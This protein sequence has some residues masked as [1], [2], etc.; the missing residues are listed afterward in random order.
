MIQSLDRS[1]DEPLHK[2]LADVLRFAI[3]NGEFPPGEQIPSE[4]RLQS[5]F[6]VSRSVVRQALASLTSL[7]LIKRVKGSGAT[8]VSRVT[9]HRLVQSQIGLAAQV[10]SLGAETATIVQSM[11]RLGNP[12]GEF[13]K[14]DTGILFIERI[15]SVDEVPIA[16]V[17][18]WLPLPQFEGLT[19]T[20][21]EN[22]SLHKIMNVRYGISL[23]GGTR[24]VRA[25]SSDNSLSK[26]LN[27]QKGSPLLL[28]TGENTDAQGLLVERFSTWHRSDLVS[29]DFTID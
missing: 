11:E 21:L 15:Q 7:G 23:A 5:L 10:S 3:Q 13:G 12:D 2:Q 8:V 22:S 17:Q 25:I 9:Y 27:I 24:Q 1:N 20:D 19:Q 26:K 16:V 4:M 14:E 6:N 18:T 29:L 28:L